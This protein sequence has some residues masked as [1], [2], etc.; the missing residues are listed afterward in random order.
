[1]GDKEIL[2]IL[3]YLFMVSDPWPLEMGDK[4]RLEDWLNLECHKHGF[5]DWIEAYHGM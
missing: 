5:A 2:R 1:M 3:C 4:S